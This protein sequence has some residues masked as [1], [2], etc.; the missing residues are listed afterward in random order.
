MQ[1]NKVIWKF[2]LSALVAAGVIVAGAFLE[3]LK[4]FVPEP[5]VQAII[6]KAAGVTLIGLVTAFLNW[7]KH[8]D[9]E[10]KN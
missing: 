5:G 2:V 9:T 4:V 6:W 1:W 8:K 10:I 3:G 7:L